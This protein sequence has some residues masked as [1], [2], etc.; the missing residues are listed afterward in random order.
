[1]L[2]VKLHSGYHL[3]LHTDAGIFASERSKHLFSSGYNAPNPTRVT[4]I[5]WFSISDAVQS[6][7]THLSEGTGSL[8]EKSGNVDQGEFEIILNL[9]YLTIW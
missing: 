8:Q 1:M 4:T 5:P 2:E 9:I 7:T 6:C 3:V